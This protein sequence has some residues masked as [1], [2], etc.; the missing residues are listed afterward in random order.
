MYVYAGWGTEVYAK[1]LRAR[2]VFETAAVQRR[3]VLRVS[4]HTAAARA[5]T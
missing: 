5:A 4:A 1:A 2:R 3:P